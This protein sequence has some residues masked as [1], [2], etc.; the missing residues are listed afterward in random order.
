MASNGKYYPP[1]QA[2]PA[3]PTRWEHRAVQVHL[4][5]GGLKV[6]W[7]DGSRVD[8]DEALTAIG[9]SGWEIVAAVPVIAANNQK[10]LLYMRKPVTDPA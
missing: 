9:N 5:M 8:L 3:Q 2:A 7:P 1:R 6:L 10:H 4:T